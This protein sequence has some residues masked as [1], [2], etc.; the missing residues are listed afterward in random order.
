MPCVSIPRPTSNS[1]LEN[2]FLM[3][4]EDLTYYESSS[5]LYLIGKVLEELAPLKS[6]SSKMKIEWKLH[7][8]LFFMDLGNGFFFNEF[9][10]FEDCFNVCQERHFIQKS[11]YY[12]SKMERGI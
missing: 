8:S 10:I 6:I 12:H 3:N 2:L 7:M 5:K 1:S 9:S 11:S 4:E